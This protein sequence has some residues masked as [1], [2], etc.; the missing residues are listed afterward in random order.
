M[1]GPS[2]LTARAASS[3]TVLRLAAPEVHALQE[4][5]F[6]RYPYAEWATFGRFGWRDTPHGLVLSLA[7]LD[8][9]GAGDLDE[10]V[11]HV[12]IAEPY[13]LRVALTAET[14]PLA[15]GV[16]HSHP[17]DYAPRPSPIDDDMDR[18]YAGYLDGF[19]RGRPYV[20]LI[21][22]VVEDEL[23]VS[24]RVFWKG[25]WVVVDRVVIERNPVRAW[26]GGARPLPRAPSPERTARL[27][28]AFGDEA[29]SRLRESTVAVIGAGGTG[30]AAIEVLARAG[31]GRLIIVDP[32]VLEESNLERIHGSVPGHAANRVP[33]VVL[34]RDHVRAIDS[35]IDVQAYIGS[36]PQREVL[37]A[38]V[39]AN[40]L[41]GCTDQQHSR[42]AV[43]DVAIRYLV[44]SL[45][46]GVLLEGGAGKITGQIAQILRVLPADPCP[47]C[48]EMIVP[49]R[50][51]QEL[52]SETERA[53]RRLA[54][55]AACARGEEPDPYWQDQPQLNTVGYHT[56]MVGAM[57][58]GYA[59]GWLTGR[60]DP[61]F[62]RLQMNLVAPL[63]DV[64]D[65]DVSAGR[66]CVCRR[67]R[68]WADQ[69][70]ADALITPPSHWPAVRPV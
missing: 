69:G 24:G 70:V 4:L 33:K 9:P 6:R 66:D 13:S 1:A 28:A 15:V 58:A 44:P 45:D 42:L 47:W 64:T 50:V 38:V 62:A 27:A 20:S 31:V 14:H 53:R 16:I 21:F 52:M 3:P 67:I 48:R 35:H 59:I 19:T 51:A 57:I 10:H 32:D 65:V 36:L 18:Y 63:L 17:R 34:A 61:P 56:T 2:Q 23:A 7:A 25:K 12:A 11:G 49:Q 41:L 60:F 5:V 37:D 43:A 30:S 55:D 68:G 22:A 29:A 40:V 54:A 39:T 46:C 26:V 8:P